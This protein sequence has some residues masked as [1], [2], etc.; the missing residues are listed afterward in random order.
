MPIYAILENG[1]V[2]NAIVTDQDDANKKGLV[3]LTNGAGIGWSFAN[4][5]FIAPALAEV[6][7]SVT[8][9]SV[10]MDR[11]A[12]L[13]NTDWTQLSDVPQEVKDRYVQYRQ[14][15]RDLPTQSGFPQTVTWPTQ[16]E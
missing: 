16:P 13:S 11:N 3:E 5:I 2:V 9:N 12:L 10:R 14:A 4:G 7:I 8:E 6:P 15:L 1:L